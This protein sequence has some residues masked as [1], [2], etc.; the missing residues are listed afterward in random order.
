MLRKRQQKT[1]CTEFHLGQNGPHFLI[2]T[3]IQYS[4]AYDNYIRY[5]F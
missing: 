5:L 2:S 1:F 4:S 3:C